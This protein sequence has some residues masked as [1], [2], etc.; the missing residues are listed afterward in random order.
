[1]DVEG[2]EDGSR[3]VKKVVIGGWKRRRLEVEVMVVIVARGV[4]M[5][6]GGF[7]D[8]EGEGEFVVMVMGNG[9]DVSCWVDGLLVQLWPIG[10]VVGW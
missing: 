4:V 8:A 9:E 10:W 1:L 6:W 2:E 5:V 3:A 7:G